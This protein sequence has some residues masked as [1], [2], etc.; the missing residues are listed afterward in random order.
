M[1][2][3]AKAGVH[4]APDA[5]KPPKATPVCKKDRRVKASDARWEDIF[6]SMIFLAVNQNLA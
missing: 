1:G 5:T 6:I 3:A 2:V 4:G